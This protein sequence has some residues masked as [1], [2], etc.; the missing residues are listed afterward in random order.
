MG[1]PARKGRQVT[2]TVQRTGRAEYG[3]YIKALVCGDPGAGKTRFGRS[4]PGPFY[5]NANE[6]LMSVAADDMPFV[7]VKSTSTIEEA[8][9]VLRQASDVREKMLGVPVETVI[10]DTFDDIQR[11]L[12]AERLRSERKE[13][14]AQADWGW[15]GDQCRGLVR[16]LRNLDMNVL[17]LCHIKGVQDEDTGKTSV[18]PQL[19][20][21]FVDEFAGYVDLALL[22]NAKTVPVVSA[23]NEVGRARAFIVQTYPDP[24][25]SWIKDRSGQLP[26]EFE[27]NFEDDYKRIN[28]MVFGHVDGMTE[29]RIVK[30]AEVVVAQAAPAPAPAEAPLVASDPSPASTT[31]AASTTEAPAAPVESAP[32]PSV[33]AAPESEPKVEEEPQRAH[34]E[35]EVPEPQPAAPALP[36]P[37]PSAPQAAAEPAAE[38]VDM[39]CERCGDPIEDRDQADLSYIRF[40]KR[41]DRKCFREAKANK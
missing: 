20:G 3:R 28:D 9:V 6:G 41:L 23:N 16:A 34:P 10:V 29:S 39:K 32:A 1:A 18:K 38:E 37:A 2:L 17:F 19:Q 15:L 7:D 26:M 21:A 13:S 11:L 36:D 35:P 8:M 24:Q 40:R 22:L 30:E 25:H 33:P 4:W 14:M 31:A 27:L 5:L 12:I